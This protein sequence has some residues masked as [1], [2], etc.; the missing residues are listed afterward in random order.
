M[1]VVVQWPVGSFGHRVLG[2]GDSFVVVRSK[3]LFFGWA[4]RGGKGN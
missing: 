3:E 1:V 2:C 4:K